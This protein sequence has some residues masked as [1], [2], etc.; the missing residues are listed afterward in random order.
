MGFEL[1]IAISETEVMLAGLLIP[2]P[3]AS[4]LFGIDMSPELMD[5]PVFATAQAGP[6]TERLREFLDL[7]N[8]TLFTDGLTGTEVT[9]SELR[10]GQVEW[11]MGM[12]Q[13]VEQGAAPARLDVIFTLDSGST[14]QAT[15]IVP[16][17]L[18]ARMAEELA[19]SAA[20]AAAPAE[21]PQ[22]LPSGTAA[23]NALF[24]GAGAGNVTPFPAAQSPFDGGST[25]NASVGPSADIPVHPVRY[26]AFSTPDASGAPSRPIDILM[27]VAMRVSVEL[28]RS[29]LTVEEILELGPGSV[30][31]LNK[32]AGEPVD[33]L[34]NER[35]IARGEVV[36][37]DENFGVRIT[38][39][40]SPRQR[41]NAIGR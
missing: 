14:A 1:R 24:V 32:L 29:S 2:L 37:V 40:I 3:S 17:S 16:V 18:L 41:A 26:H 15:L 36:V 7:V 5:D 25:A 23:A 30:V 6:L 22:T 38:E 4:V 19:P 8:L 10:R 39:I 31:E 35:L 28:G 11:T 34:V 20:P 21:A 9:V 27:D 13:N 33:V 12:V